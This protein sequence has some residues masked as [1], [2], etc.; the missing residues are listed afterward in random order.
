MERGAEA[1]RWVEALSKRAAD[2][3]KQ[4]IPDAYW[5][6][7]PA[8][9]DASGESRVS[10]RG[11]VLLQVHGRREKAAAAPAGEDSPSL[12]PELVAALAERPSRPGLELL[13]LLAADGA[14]APAV[15]VTALV[16]SALGLLVEAV[17]LRGSFEIGRDLGLPQQR[18]G[19]VTAFGIFLLALLLIELPVAFG[20]LSVGRHLETRLRVAF[21]RKIPRLADR[22]FQSRL[23]SDMAERSHSVQGL[24]LLPALGSDLVRC[25]LQIA[26][27]TA[28][29][30]W[31][32]P[33]GFALALGAGGAALVVPLL[34]QPLLTERDLRV[35]THAGALGRFYLDALLGLVAVRA[36]G[37][38][39]AVRREHESLL[40]EWAR[41]VARLAR[42][43]L[44][45]EALQAFTGFALAAWLL[46]DYVGKRDRTS[47]V[48]LLA[49]WALELPV[50]GREL[51][52]LAR[53][54][55]AR[56]NVTL[57]V[58][59]PLGAP[60]SRAPDAAG[61]HADVPVNDGGGVRIEM[62]NVSVRA[63][64]HS[65]LEG[66]GLRVE[67]GSHVAIVGPSGSGK[68][69]LVGLM[70]GWH[71]ASEGTVMV[72]GAPLVEEHVEALRRATAWVDPSVHLF[73]ARLLD[74]LCY[75][76]PNDFALTVGQV[77]ETA[78]LRRVLERLPEGLQTRLGEGGGLVSG[79]EGQRVRFGRALA[80]SGVRLAVLDEPFRGLDRDRRRA[81]LARA[82]TLWQRATMLCVTHDVGETRD[83]DRVIVV[84]NGRVVEDGSPRR[85]AEVPGSRYRAMIDAETAVRRQL[86]SSTAWRKL[87]LDA[88]VLVET[89]AG[90]EN[91]AP[92]GEAPRADEVPKKGAQA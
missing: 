38:E 27:T 75:G 92:R 22:Y 54:I 78:D 45:V 47:G 57:R 66:I 52:V 86:W 58:L 85:L 69:T 61:S 12:S 20:A 55:P 91:G 19:A 87:R 14:L 33:A 72:D 28:G 68:S 25:A 44:G 51:A 15:V 83:F 84:E 24:R 67:P 6:A 81:L 53:Q 18:L 37:A 34:A 63:G 13:R 60:E 43:A 31:L 70:L 71:R 9:A 82:R 36:H 48:L 49:Y 59:E 46:I 42:A 80:Q 74:N 39:K 76:A 50:L 5:F 16:F 4:A 29:L 64:G 62:D 8:P 90:D 3:D 77:I 56:R 40:S 79:G 11:A 21:L 73:N 10:L 89:I 23:M 2:G 26:L 30:I 65:I 41:A 7:V 1:A 17:L 88:G 35:R 32:D